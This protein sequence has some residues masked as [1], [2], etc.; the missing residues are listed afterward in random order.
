[1][2]RTIEMTWKNSLHGRN[3]NTN[4]D[5]EVEATAELVPLVKGKAV[6][7]NLGKSFT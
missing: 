2:E 3:L 6:D 7:D 1:M 4:P 5:D